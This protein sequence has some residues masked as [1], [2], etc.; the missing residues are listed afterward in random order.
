MTHGNPP[1]W[2]VVN[3][4]AAAASQ[5][6]RYCFDPAATPLWP[7]EA[8]VAASA[9]IPECELCGTPRQFEFQVHLANPPCDRCYMY[10]FAVALMRPGSTGR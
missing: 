3:D 6:I 1:D 8:P 5:V 10:H 7:A 2:Q 4:S 9:D